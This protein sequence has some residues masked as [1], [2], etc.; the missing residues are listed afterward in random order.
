M[1]SFWNDLRI[2]ARVLVKR[3]GF[4]TVIV[5]TLA[6]GIGANTMIFTVVNA[7]LIRPLPF[8]DADRLAAVS[9][10][11]PHEMLTPASWPEFQR[12]RDNNQVFE[13]LIASFH[14]SRNL[15]GR[16]EPARVRAALVSRNFFR[17][18]GI[19]PV[20]GRSFLP[21]EHQAGAEPVAAIS[22]ELWTREF[23][24]DRSAI[25]QKITLDRTLYTVVGVFDPAP[26]R[27]GSART[28]DVWV[29]LERQPS[30]TAEGAHYLSV[31]GRLKAGVS[32]EQARASLTALGRGREHGITAGPLRESLFG[33]VRPS[34]LLLLGAAGFLLLIAAANV[35]NI[36][37]ARASSRSK[38]FAIRS[39]L[40][41]GRL[42]LIR[43]T[44]AE[45]LLLAA[46]GGALGLLLSEWGTGLLR[47]FLPENM[48]RPAAFYLDWRVM[49]FLV[50]SSML[51]GIL[52]GLAPALQTSAV[53]LGESLKEGWGQSSSAARTRLRSAFMISEIAVASVLLAGAGL[54]LQ[55]FWRVMQVD[56]GFQAENVLTLSISLPDAKY[57]DD[58]KRIAFFENVMGRIRALPGVVAV[59]GADHVPM[60]DGGVNGDFRLADRPPFPPGE[61]PVTE[62]Y[63]ATPD[64][65][66]AMGM[67]LVRGRW[68]NEQDGRTG[69]R[70][71]IINESFARRFW[72]NEVPIGKRMDLF[73]G[74][75]EGW[76]EIVGVVADVRREGLD[77][78]VTLEGYLPYAQSALNVMTL[79]VRATGDPAQLASAV[80]SQVL[81][82]DPEQPVFNVK[83]MQQVVSDSLGARRLST[84][85]LALFAGL[86]MLLAAIGIYGV[87][88][89]WVSQRTR[90][91]GI[92]TALG[93]ERADILRLVLGR[94]MLLVG[95]GV[96]GGLLASLALTRFLASL[97]FGVSTHDALTMAA[98]PVTLGLIALAACY[99]PAR[100][101][102]RVDPLVALR[103]E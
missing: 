29:P 13:E 49:L 57:G 39:A 78:A 91:I 79:A 63:A 83:T 92:R 54:L 19:Q 61:S 28:E 90:E 75:V 101:A 73:Y 11:Q 26:L 53:S 62:K 34:L 98:V 86:A 24:G 43:H 44:I 76:Q 42:R 77:R 12:W 67:R 15:I 82:V 102:A 95:I 48:A 35:G 70:A 10:V 20:V 87:V 4:T 30:Y 17:L 74:S 51:C 55:S 6:L 2:A 3:L 46:A 1:N 81:A 56:P 38:E 71:V 14:Q 89:Y 36:L 84:F 96:V 5:L 18:L 27:L 47:T 72:P 41:A 52:F 22:T 31:M 8:A 16:H 21:D 64:Y 85:L 33:D 97:L 7:Y 94:G 103:F 32:M 88:S 58:Q 69:R 9:D 93:A 99:V 37:L 80:R 100:R 65:F 60:D 66:R 45:S 59:G 50:A 40:G 68:F 23:G 25:G